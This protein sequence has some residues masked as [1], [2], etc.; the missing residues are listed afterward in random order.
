VALV[1]AGEV[2]DAGEGGGRRRAAH[3]AGW[4]RRMRSR[5]AIMTWK[6]GLFQYFRDMGNT[7]VY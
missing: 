3:V 5:W 6:F 7:L 4:A 2:A 1:S